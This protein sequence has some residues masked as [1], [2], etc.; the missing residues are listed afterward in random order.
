[1]QEATESRTLP[2]EEWGSPGAEE[3]GGSPGAASFVLS[4]LSLEVAAASPGVSDFVREGGFE[5]LHARCKG[6]ASPPGLL[7]ASTC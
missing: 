6:L 2:E 1:M 5:A 3:E 7:G 4:G